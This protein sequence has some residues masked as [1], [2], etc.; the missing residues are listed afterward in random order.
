[1][2]LLLPQYEPSSPFSKI[3]I[4][5]KA[6]A[7][8]EELKAKLKEFLAD[9]DQSL[10]EKFE[11]FEENLNLLRLRNG[12]L[13][14][15]LKTAGITV[16]NFRALLKSKNF[17]EKRIDGLME[18]A[19]QGN[20]LIVKPEKLKKVQLVYTSDGQRV[21]RKYTKRKQLQQESISEPIVQQEQ[22][23]GNLP[24]EILGNE[25][26]FT[27][28][29]EDAKKLAIKTD[30]SR[31]I[32]VKVTGRSRK[33]LLKKTLYA[34]IT[35]RI[36]KTEQIKRDKEKAIRNRKKSRL[37]F[38]LRKLSFSLPS[39]DLLHNEEPS[40]APSL[41]LILE[42]KEESTVKGLDLNEI[43][44]NPLS[45]QD[46][47]NELFESLQVPAGVGSSGTLSPTVAFLMS[48]PVVSTSAGKIPEQHEE[49][50]PKDNEIE[51]LQLFNPKEDFSTVLPSMGKSDRNLIN[52]T[53][54]KDIGNSPETQN[55]NKNLVL[56]EFSESSS[57]AV[58][59][60]SSMCAKPVSQL[61]TNYNASSLFAD[62][63]LICLDKTP[64]TFCL[65]STANSKN[66]T[67]NL[68]NSHS[69]Q[70]S[71]VISEPCHLNTTT[72]T[73]TSY[74]SRHISSQ[75]PNL[76][77]DNNSSYFSCD[78]FGN[79][80][81]SSTAMPEFTFS[82]SKTTTTSSSNS[83]V[84]TLINPQSNYLPNYSS[85][86]NLF[87]FNSIVTTS[88]SLADSEAFT[89]FSFTSSS[90]IHPPPPP[91]I[92]SHIST[93][94]NSN[95]GTNFTF[96]LSTSGAA[97][98][99][100]NEPKDN[101]LNALNP[102]SIESTLST[103]RST[104]S[105]GTHHEPI[106]NYGNYGKDI[107]NYPA[108]ENIIPNNATL[109]TLDEKNKTKNDGGK[110]KNKSVGKN[111]PIEKRDSGQE[112]K[113]YQV[114][115]M[116]T[117]QNNNSSQQLPSDFGHVLPF[118]DFCQN[119]MPP[120]APFNYVPPPPM[121]PQKANH[122]NQYELA[123]KSDIFFAHPP[124]DNFTWSPSKSSTFGQSKTVPVTN[125]FMPPPLLTAPPPTPPIVTQNPS[126]KIINKIEKKSVIQ[127]NLNQG[128]GS[129]F[130]V[131]NL[132][133]SNKGSKSQRNGGGKLGSQAAQ[134][135]K[136]PKQESQEFKKNAKNPTNYEVLS[137][138][139]YTNVY[140]A[141]ALISGGPGFHNLPKI[142]TDDFPE[143]VHSNSNYNQ[144]QPITS[145]YN[146][147]LE[148]PNSNLPSMQPEAEYYDYSLN[149]HPNQKL[150]PKHSS[151]HLFM[152]SEPSNSI[153]F[154]PKSGSSMMDYQPSSNDYVQPIAPPA[155]MLNQNHGKD[156]NR[157]LSKSK[158]PEKALEFY[159][160]PPI[161]SI[162]HQFNSY[163]PSFNAQPINQGPSTPTNLFSPHLNCLELE[164]PLQPLQ[165]FNYT[166]NYKNH[167]GFGNNGVEVNNGMNSGQTT[168]T[169]YSGNSLTNFNLSSICP[170][171]NNSANEKNPTW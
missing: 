86:Q 153:Y 109:K 132:V 123:K 165:H 118:P 144:N 50:L 3:E 72:K 113:K 23:S 116:A 28:K 21:K 30:S 69:N 64:F 157:Q 40:K 11:E 87:G 95:S 10:L 6:I 90:F 13:N 67:S 107:H 65:T 5:Q 117:S 101:Y 47:S 168:T 18:D 155:D 124:E 60:N 130:S 29:L 108:C 39:S 126:Q 83:T 134:K 22:E 170:E 156:V 129:C 141:E 14:E 167:Q 16:P 59:N 8:I 93:A 49:R 17:T 115:W 97:K 42:N 56:P 68:N 12:Q 171:I 66:I 77:N 36:L 154:P 4:L 58:Y 78:F 102:F 24:N 43:L 166:N 33:I 92:S 55:S 54:Q 127:P 120:P 137:S 61:S 71:G 79:S 169:N 52:F 99:P 148:Y 31:F 84:P 161:R 152:P 91:C 53:D 106:L 150:E 142:R 81:P 111:Q 26:I 82:L 48:F 98:K 136:S 103:G 139:S 9:K 149:H 135:W 85:Q 112:N 146:L 44:P 122:N 158:K 100:K 119:N 15:L 19:N 143:K 128:Y 110:M 7:Y 34:Q 32:S 41:G 147:P 27:E 105:A 133:E 162:H 164:T 163:E 70:N 2:S 62:S 88:N 104:M 114:N 1:M 138:Q 89:P 76:S 94:A 80:V 74:G 20:E 45:N 63:N 96:S 160:G 121:V 73:T 125:N 37:K 131:S 51:E 75:P 38:K 46:L 145:Q 151:H 140:S 159:N 35:K 25:G 57:C